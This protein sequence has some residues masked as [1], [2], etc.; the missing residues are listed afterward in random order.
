M[1]D[2]WGGGGWMGWWGLGG[3]VGAGWGGGGWVGWVRAALP[4]TPPNPS[5]Y[6]PPPP[7]PPTPSHTHTHL[8][9]QD[10][11]TPPHHPSTHFAVAAA[12]RTWAGRQ[13]ASCGCRRVGATSSLAPRPPKSSTKSAWGPVGLASWTSGEDGLCLVGYGVREGWEGACRAA[14]SGGLAWR[15]PPLP[16]TLPPSPP[17][18][19]TNPSCSFKGDGVGF[20]CGGSGSLFRTEDGGATWRR[21]R[22]ADGVA[23]NLYAV[24]FTGSGGQGGNGFILGNDGILLRYIGTA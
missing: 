8:S 9:P 14:R 7:P 4:T 22:S 19:P 12:S 3:V 5:H 18:A 20:A 17:T 16:L 2:G 11:P 15:R 23:G 6:P 21:D 1:E 10:L 24:T 13:T